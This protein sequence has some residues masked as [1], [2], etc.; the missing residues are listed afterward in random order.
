MILGIGADIVEVARFQMWANFPQSRLCKIFSVQEIES[1]KNLGEPQQE[2]PYFAYCPEKLASRF[3]AKEAFYKALSASLVK[4]NLTQ[5][6]F[7]LMFSC[8]YVQ[9]IPTTWGIPKLEVNW[10]CFEEKIGAKLPEVQVDLSLAHER[11]HAIAFVLI[12]T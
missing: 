2:Q 6:Q 5:N 8:N 11:L 3:A 4:L 12:S 9:V 10:S 7:S 1:C